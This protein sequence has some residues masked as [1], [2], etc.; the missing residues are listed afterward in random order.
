[1]LKDFE[2]IFGENIKLTNNLFVETQAF[3]DLFKDCLV[4]SYEELM[5]IDIAKGYGYSKYIEQWKRDGLIE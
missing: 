5:R 3:A 4:V 1:M 2:N